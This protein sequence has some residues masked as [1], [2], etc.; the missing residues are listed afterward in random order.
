MSP[1]GRE[2]GGLG[3]GI[4]ARPVL[5]PSH[6]LVGTENQQLVALVR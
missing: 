2:P 3:D 6:V 5:G 1:W 4:V